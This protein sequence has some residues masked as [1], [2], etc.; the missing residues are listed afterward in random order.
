MEETP[1]IPRPK[2]MEE[3]GPDPNAPDEVLKRLMA[4]TPEQ[5]IEVVR[6]Y[7][8]HQR[9]DRGRWNEDYWAGFE[10][11]MLLLAPE[12]WKE[13]PMGWLT[14]GEEH[15]DCDVWRPGEGLVCE[16]NVTCER[17]GHPMFY[18]NGGRYW[19]AKCGQGAPAGFMEEPVTPAEEDRMMRCPDCGCERFYLSDSVYR[20]SNCNRGAPVGYKPERRER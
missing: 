2:E 14:Y 6:H 13:I 11:A 4:L 20:C 16:R 8:S 1:G 10:Y 7:F 9:D 12:G 19:C 15:D 17:C 3:K 5:R 18:P